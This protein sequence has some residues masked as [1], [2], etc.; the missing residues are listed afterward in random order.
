MGMSDLDLHM[1]LKT[2]QA[3]SGELELD[4]LLVKMMHIV[5]ENTGAQNG[6]LILA[7]GD[8]WRIEAMAD[9]NKAKVQV[10]Q[11]ISIEANDKVSAS[12]IQYVAHTQKTVLLKDATNEGNFTSDET[13]QLRQSKSVLCIPL[14]NQGRISGIM[15][16]ENNLTPNAFTPGHVELLKLLSSVMAMALDNAK[17]YHNLEESEEKFKG[18]FNAMIDVFTRTDMDG[19]CL[20]V[21]PSIYNLL[22]Y[23]Q[24]EVL[25][26]N[27]ASF[28]KD[29]SQRKELLKKL[30][31]HGTIENFEFSAVRKD[32]ATITVSA[33]SK[34]VYDR[35][36]KPMWVEGNIRN[37]NEIKKMENESRESE[38]RFRATFEQAAVGI[39]HVGTDGRFLRINE[40]FCKIVGYTHEEMLARTFQDITHP[41]DLDSDIELVRKVLKGKI[42]NYSLEKRYY[43]K[44][45]RIIWVHLTVSLV[46]DEGDEPDYF[47]SVVKEISDRKEVEEALR[48]S[49][50]FLEHLI[51]AM[52]DAVF[53]IKMPERTI[54]WAND[55]FDV[56]GYTPEEYVGRSVEDFYADPEDYK[57]V[58]HIQMEAA[59]R[60]DKKIS[61]EIMVRHKDGRTF[62]AELTGTFFSEQGEL[63]QIT[64]T[65]RDISG[66]KQVEEQVLNYQQRLKDL[67]SELTITE[68]MVRKQ[69]AIDL[70]DHVGQMLAAIRM[71]LSSIYKMK[72]IQKITP[73][74]ES[75]SMALKNAI[76]A[77][78]SAIFTL[79][80]PQL[81]EI[82]LYA[83]VQ[84][85]INQEITQKYH[86]HVI[87][88]GEDRKIALDE[89]TNIL[90]Y[91]SIRELVMNVIKHSE[92]T[93]LEVNFCLK[94]ES[95]ETTVRDNGKGFQYDPL[96]LR[97]KSRSFGLFSINERMNDLGGSLEVDSIIG[98]GSNIKLVIPVK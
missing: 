91:R 5:I 3:I 1:V 70:H 68:E 89:N 32:G 53:S 22:G 33:N 17:I 31:D 51:T 37:I 2:S 35:D 83:A 74:I 38:K 34:L 15:Y 14:I 95:F 49:R 59:Q 62:P 27:L 61:T 28:Y 18:V 88:S 98:K 16:L 60:G 94:K 39:A 81:S 58:G 24:E 82:S 86:L 36:G 45:G 55:S 47:V 78:R 7:K 44:D 87:V 72:E 73:K 97:L 26:K 29:P 92:A 43:R 12:I 25:G 85:W 9:V 80:P 84:D 67:A 64:A 66:P 23:K 4:K 71:Q 46:F 21:S 10:L 57:K 77:T 54:N 93:K 48:Q 8:E 41:E 42:E 65:V 75:I 50:D 96:L 52:P 13:V 30:L 63:H 90:L 40:K 19:T 76:Q 11:S 20:V 6:F 79:S 56:M 69:I